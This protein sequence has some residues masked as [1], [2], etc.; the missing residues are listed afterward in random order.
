MPPLEARLLG[1][2]MGHTTS[3]GALLGTCQEPSRA[4]CSPAILS[5]DPP[6]SLGGRHFILNIQMGKLRHRGS[7]TQAK[8]P[9]RRMW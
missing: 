1:F 6:I 2:S 5:W 3:K 8:V 4:K 7:P 9:G